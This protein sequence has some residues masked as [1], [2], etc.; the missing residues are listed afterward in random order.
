MAGANPDTGTAWKQIRSLAQSDVQSYRYALSPA[1]KRRSVEQSAA[2]HRPILTGEKL[3]GYQ[4]DVLLPHDSES[5]SRRKTTPRSPRTNHRPRTQGGRG[6]KQSALG[7]PPR[8]K[9]AVRKAKTRRRHTRATGTREVDDPG[10][11]KSLALDPS[12]LTQEDWDVV[13]QSTNTDGYNPLIIDTRHRPGTRAFDATKSWLSRSVRAT[14]DSSTSRRRKG[15]R[16]R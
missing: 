16:A 4:R 13:S 3:A 8:T 1:S 15:T 7:Q 14:A 9:P 5:R 10:E 6:S 2:I 12:I 11:T